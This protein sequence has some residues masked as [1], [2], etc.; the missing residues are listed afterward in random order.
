MKRVRE[1]ISSICVAALAE[2]EPAPLLAVVRKKRPRS[3]PPSRRPA[4]VPAVIE[5]PAAEA[6]G[7]VA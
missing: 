1:P 5:L 6:F 7:P 4:S 2:S 3:R